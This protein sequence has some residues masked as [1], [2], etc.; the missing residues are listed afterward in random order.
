MYVCLL[1]HRSWLIIF[2]GVL[3]LRFK[4]FYF[5]HH[6]WPQGWI[7]EAM[8]ILQSIWAHYRPAVPLASEL[9]VLPI[10]APVT[11]GS[12]PKKSRVD[13]DII[14]NYG[15][16]V[17]SGPDALEEYLRAL[18]LPHLTD[19]LGYWLKQWK[20]GEATGDA[21]N[22]ALAQMALDYLSVPGSFFGFSF[23]QAACVLFLI[24][25]FIS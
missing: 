10:A 3:H 23:T 1:S 11:A 18:P 13:F 6:K 20:A 14:L 8:E 4:K 24:S 17:R 21:S 22:T 12:H 16:Q 25:F 15:H 2:I 9:P 5:I 19:P 7:D